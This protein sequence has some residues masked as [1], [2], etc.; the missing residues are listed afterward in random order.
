M[1]GSDNQT[2]TLSDPASAYNGNYPNAIYNPQNSDQ[3]GIEPSIRGRKLY[4]PLMSWFTYST[5]TA[6]PLIALQYQKVT[7]KNRV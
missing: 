2:K 7:I 6:L 3:Q 1:T 5:K 4:I